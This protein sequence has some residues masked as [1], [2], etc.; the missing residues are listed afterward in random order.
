MPKI[1]RAD[2][3]GA[4]NSVTGAPSSG[5]VHDVTPAIV[6]AIAQLLEGHS[7]IEQRVIKPTETRKAVSD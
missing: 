5:V 6:Q 3:E 1:S 2:I 7:E 4:I